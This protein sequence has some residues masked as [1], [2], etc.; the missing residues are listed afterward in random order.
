MTSREER[1]RAVPAQ[2]AELAVY[3][4]GPDPGPDVPT[5]L[6]VHGYPDDHHVYLPLI[7]QLSGTHHIITYD[8]RNAGLSSVTEHPGDFSLPALV[9]DL[10]AVLSATQASSVHLVGH[11]WGSI[12][13]WAAIQDP[14]AAGRI[15]R[16]T[17]ISGP[18]LRHLAW[19]MRQKLRSPRDWAQ[20]MGQ[21]F[22]SLYVGA[23][24]VPGLPE[25]AWRFILTGYYEKARNRR[26]GDNPVRGLAL[27]RA[28]VPFKGTQLPVPVSV[29]V[30]VVVPDKDP[31]LSPHLTDGL[32]NWASQLTI[33]HVD[34]GHWWPETHAAG[35]ATLLQAGHRT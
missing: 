30:H 7:D 8:T 27:Y 9:D 2:G 31:F 15:I 19:W 13:A 23:F 17:S 34:A 12:Q 24:Q 35:L 5:L 21:L 20:L 16:F 22:R 29:P 10:Y 4:Y 25:A 14:R 32:E 33:T 6:L 18:D 1:T 26:V 11:D 3:E 28:N